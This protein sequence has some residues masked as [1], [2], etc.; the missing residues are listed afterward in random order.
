MTY[1]LTVIIPVYNTEK[2]LRRCLESIVNQDDIEQC[3]I[4]V[5]CINDG[6]TDESRK[7][8]EEFVEKYSYIEIFNKE[9]GGLADVRNTG[10]QFINDSLYTVSLDSDDFWDKS[11]L[12][13][14]NKYKSSN[15]DLIFFD[16]NLVDYD[17][18]P[19]KELIVNPKF[20]KYNKKKDFMV[21]KHAAWS[22][23][24]RTNLYDNIN[25]PKGKLYEDL[26]VMPYLTSRAERI[27]Y[28]QKP[29]INYVINTPGSIMNSSK[30][31]IFD[32]YDSLIHLF[33]LF[34]NHFEKYRNELQYLAIE[35]LCVGQTYRLLNYLEVTNQDFKDIVIFMEKYFGN[36]WDKNK[37]VNVGVQK[38]NINS[39]L[40]YV[41]PVLK[42]LKYGGIIKL[43]DIKR[44]LLSKK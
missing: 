30:S 10:L 5:I 7:I 36:T 12:T 13:E 37:Y 44:V 32:I 31:N 39:S 6:S 42:F 20:D 18:N 3:S 25:F 17:G 34:G 29:L 1:D 35:H 16:I 4:K 40:S 21:V 38:V 19:V 8:I 23:I 2:Y 15:Y 9:N 33:N 27:H 41:V 28:I 22:K 24:C 26:A 43:Y 14:F 11:F